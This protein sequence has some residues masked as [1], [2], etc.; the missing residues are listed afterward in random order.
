MLHSPLRREGTIR[1]ARLSISS[2]MKKPVTKQACAIAAELHTFAA[3]SSGGLTFCR[4]LFFAPGA[5]QICRPL[6]SRCRVARA[7]ASAAR[8]YL[9]SSFFHL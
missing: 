5:G 9:L 2:P 8:P 6:P 7:A 1:P 4:P 3:A